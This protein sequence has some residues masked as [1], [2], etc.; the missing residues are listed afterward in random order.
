VGSK[1]PEREQRRFPSL[2]EVRVRKGSEAWVQLYVVASETEISMFALSRM[3]RG[4][5]KEGGEFSMIIIGFGHKAQN[6]KDTA[7]EAIL[8]HF[9]GAKAACQLHGMRYR[10]PRVGI[11]KFAQPIYQE[12]NDY[13]AQIGGPMMLG[14]VALDGVILPDWVVADKNAVPNE[15][16]PYGKHSKLLQWWGTE[17]RRAQ[18]P[19]Y[20]VKKAFVSIPTDIDIAIFTDVRFRN[21]VA[22]IKA[23]GGHTV[24]VVRLNQDGSRYIDPGRD[25][26]HQSEIDL[27]GYNWDHHIVTKYAALTAEQA[28]TLAEFIV[29]LEKK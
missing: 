7:G 9:D 3:V 18:D 4:R 26:K 16:F 15:V 25:A 13:L 22:A 27:D 11:F 12:T 5:R 24:E 1:S 23:V 28:I 14:I 17:Y 21:E 2:P 8:N 10:G 6:G 29:G 19:D 20:W